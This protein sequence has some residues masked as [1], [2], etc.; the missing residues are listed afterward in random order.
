MPS[1]SRSIGTRRVT[2]RDDEVRKNGRFH[3]GDSILNLY[4]VIEELAQGGMGVVYKC[5][6]EVGKV[7]VAI[8][9]LPPEVS[10]NALE[11]EDILENYHLVRML[12]HPNIVGVTSLEQ[13]RQH[14]EEQERQRLEEERMRL[15]AEKAR[16]RGEIASQYRSATNLYNRIAEYRMQ[17]K[18]FH[19]HIEEGDCVGGRRFAVYGHHRRA[20]GGGGEGR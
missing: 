10:R 1:S 9:G 2:L 20:D 7:D 12:R 8:K 19:Q 6:D 11:M 13:E 17:S 3:S 5:R 16:L 18:G 14:K 4:T 15:K